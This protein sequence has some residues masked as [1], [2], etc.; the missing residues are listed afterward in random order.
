MRYY[1]NVVKNIVILGSTG[2]IGQNALKVIDALGAEYKVLA[3]SAHSKVELLAQQVKKYKPKAVAITNSVN[4]GQFRKLIAGCD[5]E[6]FAGSESLAAIAQLDEADI[7]LTAVVG[8]V[9]LGAVLAAAKKGKTLAI[10]N[11]EPLVIA[12]QLLTET[13]KKYGSTILPVDSE[14]SAIFQSLQAGNHDE[15]NKIII[16]KVGG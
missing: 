7:V 5:V 12:G 11:K 10:A 4:V 3:L 9:G 16:K 15:V 2:S 6:I 1:C 8:A 14:H 13:A